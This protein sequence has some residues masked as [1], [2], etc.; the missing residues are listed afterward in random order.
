MRTRAGRDDLPNRLLP[1]GL[2][3]CVL[4]PIIAHAVIIPRTIVIDGDFADWMALDQNN[5]GDTDDAGEGDILTNAQQSSSDPNDNPSPTGRDLRAF[6]FTFDDDYLYMFVERYASTSNN[7]DWWFYID[8]DADGTMDT[9]EKVLQVDWSGS[10]RRTQR[11]LYDYSP[12]DATGGDSLTDATTGSSNDYDMPGSLIN[13]VDLDASNA[14]PVAGSVSGLQMETR[15]RWDDLDPAATGPFSIGFYIASSNGTNIPNNIIDSMEGPSGP[16]GTPVFQFSEPSLTK[17]GPANSVGG[18]PIEFTITITNDGPD[19]AVDIEVTDDCEALTI[20]SRDPPL[21][22]TLL[23]GESF[24]YFDSSTTAGSYDFA[25]GIWTLHSLPATAGQNTAELTLECVVNNDEP[26]TVENTAEI[27]AL[28]SID[29]DLANNIATSDTTVVEPAPDLVIVKSSTAQHDPVNL[30]DN[31]K[32]IP[33][34]CITYTIQVFNDG[35]GRAQD[36]TIKDTLPANTVLYTGDFEQGAVECGGTGATAAGDSPIFWDEN[37]SG[38]SFSF[39][40][41]DDDPTDNGD[42]FEFLD[43]GGNPITDFTQRFDPNVRSIVVKP[44]GTMLGKCCGA[45]SAQK[46]FLIRYRVQLQ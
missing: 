37:N 6:A 38:L 30:G 10:N 11:T 39:A 1:V 42:S 16:G 33:N 31:P 9:G 46:S 41:L 36:V 17:S 15:V 2:L 44:S 26:V 22:N 32:R 4:L 25:T 3:V 13:G 12:V 24:D 45:G 43:A 34:S 8:L 19:E 20:I 28:A 7:T 27:T 21:S 29:T 35:R 40:N 23:P 14:R 18:Q 5:D